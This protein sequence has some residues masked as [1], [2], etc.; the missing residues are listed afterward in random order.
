MT[1][2]AFGA[3]FGLVPAVVGITTAYWIFYFLCLVMVQ[4]L[5]PVSLSEVLRLHLNGVLVAA[6]PLVAGLATQAALPNH[7]IFLLMIPPA[8]FGVIAVAV[9]TVAPAAFV[10]D[11]VARGRAH[12][13]SK[14]QPHVPV[15]LWRGT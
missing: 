13:W 15:N 6:P 5:I 9:L 2:A 1:G 4:R 10:S 8:V 11:D 14:L 7:D 3:Q 12:L